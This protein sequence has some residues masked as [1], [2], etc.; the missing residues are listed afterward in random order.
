M[1]SVAEAWLVTYNHW[2]SGL[3]VRMRGSRPT[4]ISSSLVSAAVS[5]A[6]TEP[7]SGL[8]TKM[9][10]PSGVMP[11]LLAVWAE[12]GSQ[13]RPQTSNA[14]RPRRRN[15][16]ETVHMAGLARSASMPSISHHGKVRPAN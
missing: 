5:I 10:V 12:V 15:R 9:V 6:D 7:E 11:I 16:G 4:I 3:N 2:P 8:T 13:R 14:G 1:V